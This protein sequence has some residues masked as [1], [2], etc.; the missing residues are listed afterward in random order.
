MPSLFPGM[1]PYIESATWKNFHTR[2][3]VALSNE[4]LR[5]LGMEYAVRVEERIYVEHPFEDDRLIGP[6][7]TLVRDTQMPVSQIKVSASSSLA[8]IEPV[9]RTLPTTTEVS[10]KYLVVHDAESEEVITVIELLSPSN[11]RKGGVGRAEYLAKRE[12]VLHSQANLVELD[13]LRGGARLPTVEPLPQGDYYAF[14]C[15]A[16][17]RPKVDVY[18]WPLN[19]RLPIIPIPLDDSDK[20]APLDLQAAFDNV[21]DESRYGTPRFYRTRVVPPLSE[22]EMLWAESLLSPLQSH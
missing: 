6:D 15:R 19:H 1:D 16:S 21:F 17:K 7:A 12:E 18:S 8:T 22:A 9:Q 10:E 20:H 2:F 11:K 14:I 13:L 5:N 3:V 4:L